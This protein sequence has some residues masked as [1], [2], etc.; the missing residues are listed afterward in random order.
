[1]SQKYT[2]IFTNIPPSPIIFPHRLTLKRPSS[3]DYIMFVGAK[4]I[5]PAPLKRLIL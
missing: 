3:M 4:F 1:M 5:S 2:K